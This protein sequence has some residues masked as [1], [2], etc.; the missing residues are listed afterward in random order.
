[1]LKRTHKLVKVDLDFDT[2]NFHG[3]G[4]KLIYLYLWCLIFHYHSTHFLAVICFF[5]ENQA[6]NMDLKKRKDQSGEEYS[7][8][9]YA[10]LSFTQNVCTFLFTTSSSYSSNFHVHISLYSGDQWNPSTCKH[11]QCSVE[12]SS[13]GCQNKRFDYEFSK[14]MHWHALL[15][16]CWIYLSFSGYLIPKGWCVLASFSSVHM[17]ETNYENPYD[18]NPW[19]WKVRHV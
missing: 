17:D 7:W 16:N 19:R 10:S 13:Q 8:T 4:V 12:K 3:Y 6:E 5:H 18:F 11:H 9:D 1:M 14:N 15:L 2:W